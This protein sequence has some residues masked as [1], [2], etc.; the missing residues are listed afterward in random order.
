MAEYNMGPF[1]PNPKGVFKPNTKYRYF[2][3][4]EYNGGSYLNINK[5]DVDGTSSIG[6][7]PYGQAESELYWMCM[8]KPGK[9]ATVAK[10]Y[11]PFVVIEDDGIWDYSVTDKVIVPFTVKELKIKGLYSG[12]VGMVISVSN[13]FKLPQN[14]DTSLDYNFVTAGNKQ[15][16]MYTFTCVDMNNTLRLIWNRTVINID[17]GKDIV[18]ESPKHTI[19]GL[20]PPPITP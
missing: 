16:Y 11:S 1:K 9:D 4:V 12:C 8:S 13:S 14:S 2:D 7:L 19:G 6:V 20:V 10:E 17:G 15:Y 18:D 5:D 3:L